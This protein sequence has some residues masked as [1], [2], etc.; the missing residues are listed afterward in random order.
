MLP[1]CERHRSAPRWSRVGVFPLEMVVGSHLRLFTE[2]T[3][4][5]THT[6]ESLPPHTHTRLSQ[7]RRRTKTTINDF[8]INIHGK[9]AGK[10]YFD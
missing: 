6:P 9:Q 7:D 1:Y 8:T 3:P 5:H 4:T 2:H 10:L